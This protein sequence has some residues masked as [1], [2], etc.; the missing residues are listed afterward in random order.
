MNPHLSLGRRTKMIVVEG[1]AEEE[2]GAH[3]R[4]NSRHRLGGNQTADT[5]GQH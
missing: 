1:G 4:F 2:G 5:R 3:T